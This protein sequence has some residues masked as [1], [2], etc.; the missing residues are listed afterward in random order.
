MNRPWLTFYKNCQIHFDPIKN[1]AAR[2]QGK[3]FICILKAIKTPTG[4][5]FFSYKYE[6]NFTLSMY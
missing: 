6:C 1:M 5:S 2:E 4:A 3:Y